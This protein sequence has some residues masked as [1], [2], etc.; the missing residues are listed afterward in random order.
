MYALIGGDDPN[1]SAIRLTRALDPKYK[2][3]VDV[4]DMTETEALAHLENEKAIY[5]LM[6]DFIECSVEHMGEAAHRIRKCSNAQMKKVVKDY[7]TVVKVSS[8]REFDETAANEEFVAAVYKAIM[9]TMQQQVI[10][11][12]EKDH[13]PS[14][15]AEKEMV[16]KQQ[17][18]AVKDYDTFE[19]IVLEVLRQKYVSITKTEIGIDDFRPIYDTIFRSWA[20]DDPTLN[21]SGITLEQL[22]TATI[23]TTKTNANKFTYRGEFT[24]QENVFLIVFASAIAL[25]VAAAV[26][27]PIIVSKTKHRR[28]AK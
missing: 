6:T 4:T 18:E 7:V 27:A 12:L 24:P 23:E 14:N 1:R 21:E 5:G 2:I 10:E 16:Y 17:L 8:F 3:N 22:T 28:R 9:L 20:L 25:G 26:V 15:N 19:E 13:K 11:A